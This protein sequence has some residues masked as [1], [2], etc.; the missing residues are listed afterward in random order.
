VKRFLKW[1]GIV[2]AGLVGLVLVG[3][4][5]LYVASEYELHRHYDVASP[6]LSIPTDP[7]EVAE[8][9]RLAQLT[10]CTHC[11]TETLGGAVVMDIE[12]VVR[13][14]APNLTTLIPNYSDVGLA[15]AM[16]K[17]VKPDGTS[18]L[19][20]PSEMLAHLDDQDVARIIAWIRTVPATAGETRTN[21][22]RPLGRYIIATGKYVPPARVI[23][24]A[25][26]DAPS[27]SL[28]PAA[29]RGRYLV[30]STCTECHGQDLMGNAFAKSPPLIVAKG[31]SL[32]DFSKLLHEG[33][34]LGGRELGLMSKAARARFV[35]LTPEETRQIH[36]FLQTL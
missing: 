20:M 6:F 17:G 31:Y 13:F 14:V 9:R 12:S 29:A 24:N 33:I 18:V 21:E 3:I 26:P 35:A 30:I 19:F 23:A 32:E 10:G 22:V 25:A 1:T 36:E 16:R 27:A 28:S 5:Y 11:H 2:V 8:G 7:A 15:T 34:A 4:A